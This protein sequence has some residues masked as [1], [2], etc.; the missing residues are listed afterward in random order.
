MR[1][2][3]Y[4]ELNTTVWIF[5]STCFLTVSNLDSLLRDPLMRV[6]L[7]VKYVKTYGAIDGS[8]DVKNVVTN[9]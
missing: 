7:R 9:Y 6:L 3:I 2:R 4:M 8:V 1:V 5:Y